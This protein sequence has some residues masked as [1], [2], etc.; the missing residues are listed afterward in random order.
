MKK[1]EADQYYKHSEGLN[2]RD[3]AGNIIINVR[4]ESTNKTA[5]IAKAILNEL[6]RDYFEKTALL[7]DN[8]WNYE[9]G[10]IT[11][12]EYNSKRVEIAGM[13]DPY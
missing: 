6:N 2:I 5:A 8:T 13:P 11:T 3:G 9:R 1:F 7:E 4:A 12:E 10:L